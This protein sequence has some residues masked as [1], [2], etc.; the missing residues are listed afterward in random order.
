MLNL[1]WRA[2]DPVPVQNEADDAVVSQVP[3][4]EAN[5]EVVPE[6]VGGVEVQSHVVEALEDDLDQ[7]REEVPVVDSRGAAG[8]PVRNTFSVLESTVGDTECLMST[9][10]DGSRGNVE[11]F[12][13][14]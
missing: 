9:V 1:V 6:R 4:V 10:V 11:V 12:P 13:D 8:I 2:P 14:R 5:R 7:E 3:F